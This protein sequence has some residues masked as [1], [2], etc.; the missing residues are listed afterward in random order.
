MSKKGFDIHRN[1]G[2][3]AHRC[4]QD[5]DDG[6]YATIRARHYKIGETHDGSQRRWTLDGAGAKGVG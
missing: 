4:R 1:I 2:I 3:M 5:D 6:H